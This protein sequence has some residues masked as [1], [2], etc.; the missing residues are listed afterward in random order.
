MF[1]YESTAVAVYQLLL[2]VMSLNSFCVL[3]IAGASQSQQVV[4][5]FLAKYVLGL[6]CSEKFHFVTPVDCSF[7]ISHSALSLNSW[8][9]SW[10]SWLPVSYSS[11]WLNY[12]VVYCFHSQ[13]M[14]DGLLDQL[15]SLQLSV[16]SSLRELWNVPWNMIECKR[17]LLVLAVLASSQHHY[18]YKSATLGVVYSCFENVSKYQRISQPNV[19]TSCHWS[20]HTWEQLNIMLE[21]PR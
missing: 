14:L 20:I 21:A 15:A 16:D 9:Y 6:C 18:L 10:C 2:R 11:Q 8:G 17:Y 13:T 7:T 3:V 5:A 4:D 19:N 12:C 1:R